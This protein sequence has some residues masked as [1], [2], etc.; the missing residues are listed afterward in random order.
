MSQGF[1]LAV[2]RTEVASVWYD[3]EV[4]LRAM[5]RWA[6]RLPRDMRCSLLYMFLHCPT[7]QVL[8]MKRCFRY[9]KK[10]AESTRFVSTF[11]DAVQ[12]NID[13]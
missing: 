6:L 1:G 13:H 9:F 3:V 8:A 2:N 7:V 12:S 11:V 4:H 5:L 10:V